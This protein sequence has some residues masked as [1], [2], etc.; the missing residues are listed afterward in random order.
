VD[1]A[2]NT[3]AGALI[4]AFTGKGAKKKQRRGGRGRKRG[5]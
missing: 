4:T 2:V 1:L 3:G 5:R